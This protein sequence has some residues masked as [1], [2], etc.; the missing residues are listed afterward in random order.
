MLGAATLLLGLV[1]G[2]TEAQQLIVNQDVELRSIDR[3]RAR[4]LFTMRITQW[5]D[6]R[7]V[8]VFVL[9][10]DAPLHK[11]FA[12][13]A[14]GV[15][16][17]QLRQTWD[18]QVFSGTGQAPLQVANEAEMVRRVSQTPGAIGYVDAAPSVPGIRVVEV[19]E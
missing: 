6:Q 18:R 11:T 15:F 5:P 1:S 8:A 7:P 17:Y 13:S 3:N 16:A 12:K 9:P 2:T 4:L 19:D 10:D 14:L